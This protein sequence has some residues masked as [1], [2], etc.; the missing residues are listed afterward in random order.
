V[1]KTGP[2]HSS[3]PGGR[4]PLRRE[5]R[6]R[7]KATLVECGLF[8]SLSLWERA[9]VRAF[10]AVDLF[11]ASFNSLLLLTYGRRPGLPP[12]VHLP[13]FAPPPDGRPPDRRPKK[14][15]PKKGGPTGRVPALRSGQPAVLKRVAALQNSLR[16]LRSLHSNNCSESELEAKA[17]C[18]AL[19]RPSLCAPPHVQR[20]E[21]P[22]PGPSLRSAF[23]S[24]GPRF[25]WPVLGLGPP[26]SSPNSVQYS[27]WHA[28]A[29]MTKHD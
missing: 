8:N 15:R 23:E 6:G 17:S 7:S 3:F 4:P 20:G 28:C 16:S 25:A 2:V 9:G 18:S 21:G 29:G 10:T 5:S 1:S 24:S 11:A 27:S 13:F 12:A 14:R 26:S 19:A 22:Q